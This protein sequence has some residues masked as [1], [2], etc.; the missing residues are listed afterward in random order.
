[1]RTLY[2]SPLCP[3][4]RKI[5]VT[6]AEKDL[7]FELKEENYWERRREFVKLNPACETPVLVDTDGTVLAESIAINEFLE[8]RYTDVNLIGKSSTEKAEVRRLVLW[9]DLKFNH[10]VT[11][12]LLYEKF[13]KRL[14]GYGEPNSDA[15]RAGKSN[16]LYHLDYIAFLTRKRKWLAGDRLSLADIAAASH[17]SVLDYFADVPWE[18][19]KDAKEWYALVKSRPSFRDILQD[20][21]S[22]IRPAA[23]YD[24][25]DF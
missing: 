18:H 10:E 12:N 7:R 13:F 16:I 11:R 4:S 15:I 20:R 9:F 23:H 17:L 8:E 24:N 2:H 25:P 1:M 6:L 19:N 21:V 22:S 5:R 14:M 3:A